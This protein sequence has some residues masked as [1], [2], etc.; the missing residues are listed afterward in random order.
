[1]VAQH[2]RILNDIGRVVP[3]ALQVPYAANGGR[4][5][6]MVYLVQRLRVQPNHILHEVVIQVVQLRLVVLKLLFLSEVLRANHR[7]G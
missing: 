5:V 7:D 6:A 3:Y 4:E 2:L 1:M